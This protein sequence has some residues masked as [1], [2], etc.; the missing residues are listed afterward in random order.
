MK[1]NEIKAPKNKFQN[2]TKIDKKIYY[3]DII[4]ITFISMDSTVQFGVKCLSTD[5]FADVEE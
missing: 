4:V 5:L 3:K 2:N 1:E